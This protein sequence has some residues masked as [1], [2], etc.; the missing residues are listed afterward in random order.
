MVVPDRDRYV[1]KNVLT[2]QA[3]SGGP[4]IL[5]FVAAFEDW[6]TMRTV[7]LRLPHIGT[8]ILRWTIGRLVVN[9]I[10]VIEGS[11]AHAVDTR[12]QRDWEWGITAGLFHFGVKNCA[13]SSP[14]AM[15]TTIA[16]R[17]SIDPGPALF[18]THDP[19]DV[20]VPLPAPDLQS[21][22]LD[23]MRARR[24]VRFFGSKPLRLGAL[25]QVIFA[26]FGIVSI[27][28]EGAYGMLPRAMTPSG[29]AR[30]P[31]EAFVLTRNVEGVEAGLHHYSAT[32]HSL[33]DCR[34]PRIP[35]LGRLLADLEWVDHA[36]AIVF[37]VANFRRTM[38]KYKHPTAYRVVMLEAGHIA[39]N[40][41]LAATAENLA[42]V[43]MAALNDSVV[44][45]VLDL[46]PVTQAVVH[47][48]VLGEHRTG[49]D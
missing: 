27:E 36:A 31:Y 6:Q 29:G 38:W 14:E 37:L 4:E 26:G 28:D 17:S 10:L 7:A 1:V 34:R 21:C 15:A 39:Q 30:H 23:V 42:A 12:Y 16:D 13:W 22:P 43:P 35:S 44:E 25:S 5:R 32:Q 33:K 18:E 46:D 19:A 24:S 41:L 47:A 8:E 9:G 49:A 40:M 48:V 2:R 45:D 11:P 3:I 20:V